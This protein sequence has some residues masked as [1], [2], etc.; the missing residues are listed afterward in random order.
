MTSNFITDNIKTCNNGGLM[1]ALGLNLFICGVYDFSLF[2]K[3]FI[4]IHEYANNTIYIS[5]YLSNDVS[6]L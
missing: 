2:Y 4:Y 6:K 3:V 1:M 5:D